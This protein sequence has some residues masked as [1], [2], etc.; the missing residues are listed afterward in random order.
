MAVTDALRDAGYV[1]EHASDGEE[2]LVKVGA[3]AF[4]A[5][6]CD[7]KMPRLDGRAFYHALSTSAPGAGKT[8]HL[9]DRRRGRHGR[10]GV[11]RTER[12]PLAR[13]AVQ[14]W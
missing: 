9:R 5:V 13:E 1:V 6:V 11:S 10:G 7:L 14:T 4:D 12:L 8:R 3:Q 2:A